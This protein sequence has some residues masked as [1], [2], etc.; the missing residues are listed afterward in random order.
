MTDRAHPHAGQAA[1]EGIGVTVVIA[2]LLAAVTAWMV[3]ATHP[4]GRPP[5][6]IGRV[7]EPLAGPYEPRLWQASTPS[8]RALTEGR[9]G[10]APLGRVLRA[11]GGVVVTGVVVG[12]Q[13]R[14]QFAVGVLERLR[15]RA[16]ELVRNPLGDGNPLPD[17]DLFT[18]R[19]IGLAAARRAGA[20]WDYAQF[21]RTLPPRTA[22]LTAAHDA[23]RESADVAVQVAQSAL[24][25]RLTRGRTA[26]RTASP[27]R[28]ASPRQ[29]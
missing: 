11:A 8:W 9:D 6:V 15:E 28:A 3:T 13:A 21:L 17:P 29:P 7:S 23:G 10:S 19:G 25:R 2:L 1:V 12:M 4:P 18:P 5:D 14:Q 24:R 22:I 20:L 27:Q 26:P 16:A